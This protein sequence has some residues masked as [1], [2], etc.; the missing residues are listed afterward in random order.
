M[1]TRFESMGV[2]LFSVVRARSDLVPDVV[3]TG[4]VDSLFGGLR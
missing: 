2:G 1:N 4:L 3:G